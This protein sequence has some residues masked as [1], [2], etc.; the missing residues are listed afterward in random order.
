MSSVLD[1][2]VA[3]EKCQKFT[4]SDLVQTMLNL[5]GYTCRLAGHPVLENSFGSG[6]I[7]TAIVKRYIDSCIAE[8]MA[9]DAISKG[10]SKDI[11]GIELDSVLF[12]SCKEKLNAIVTAYNLPPVDWHLYNCDSLFW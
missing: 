11:Y 7:L 5:A 3:K 10:L 4:P 2:K 6:N 8:G 1:N 9:R 12:A